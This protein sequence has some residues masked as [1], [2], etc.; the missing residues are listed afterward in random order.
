M[1]LN[2]FLYSEKIG[3]KNY[4]EL[5]LNEEISSNK[6]NDLFYASK[7][8]NNLLEKIGNSA[9]P[10]LLSNFQRAKQSI[11]LLE[12]A[13]QKNGEL[14]EAQI[15]LRTHDINICIENIVEEL[16]S[17]K[18]INKLRETKIINE[19]GSAL[20]TLHFVTNALNEWEDYYIPPALITDVNLE[21]KHLTE[22]AED[23]LV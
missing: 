22:I 21:L 23:Y 16:K 7:R 9:S 2:E 19:I 12:N 6:E 17:L 13:H 4:K 14:T 3:K 5:K 18:G 11:E 15:K 20:G 8:L 1:K 10:T